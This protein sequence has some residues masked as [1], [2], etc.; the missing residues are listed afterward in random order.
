MNTRNIQLVGLTVLMI[1]ITILDTADL[2]TLLSDPPRS[3]NPRH[4]CEGHAADYDAYR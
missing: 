2:N 3:P 4:K 1:N